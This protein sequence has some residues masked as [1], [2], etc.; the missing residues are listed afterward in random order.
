MHC[1]AER[2]RTRPT[3]DIWWVETI[4]A[5]YSTRPH[6][7]WH[8]DRHISKSISA[9]NWCK[10][11]WWPV[12]SNV[13]QFLNGNISNGS[14]VTH[15]RWGG[16]GNDDFIANLLLSLRLKEFWKSVN[17]WRSY[18]QKYSGLVSWL[19]LYVAFK[20][21]TAYLNIWPTNIFE[22]PA[23]FRIFLAPLL[24]LQGGDATST[25]AER[26]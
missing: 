22:W 15:L 9:Q 26:D 11:F 17:V 5:C 18:R 3:P 21:K 6:W 4:V 13:E 25:H 23:L 12:L 8:Q 10:K 7:P 1:P 24:A 20:W 16:I 19:T 2:W 14:V